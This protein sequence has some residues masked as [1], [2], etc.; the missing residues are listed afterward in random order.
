VLGAF[1]RELERALGPALAG[2]SLPP[3]RNDAEL[4]AR[5]EAALAGSARV[6]RAA[7]RLLRSVD[8]S[9]AALPD[10]PQTLPACSAGGAAAVGPC[11]AAQSRCSACRLALGVNPGLALSCDGLDDGVANGTCAP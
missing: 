10:L 8:R 2:A 7:E 4:S 1:G 3:A 5:V 11:V 6:E 9:C